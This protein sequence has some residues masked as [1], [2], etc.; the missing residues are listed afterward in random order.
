MRHEPVGAEETAGLHRALRVRL[1]A[2]A[3]HRRQREVKLGRGSSFLPQ[4]AGR[5]AA[6]G[7]LLHL[8]LRA[9][10]GG[11]RIEVRGGA[12]S[13]CVKPHHAHCACPPSL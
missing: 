10:M 8:T 2:R 5:H 9:A 3:Q 11:V 4:A 13:R 7:Q 12:G 1:T 6:L